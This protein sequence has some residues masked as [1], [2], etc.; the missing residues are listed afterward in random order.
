MGNC[1]AEYSKLLIIDDDQSSICLL[2]VLLRNAGYCK[3]NSVTDPREASRSYAEFEPDL[4]LVDILMPYLDGLEVIEALQGRIP[5]NNYVPIVVLTADA[6]PS[7]RQRALSM[8]VKDFLT[9]PF[10]QTELV[11]RIANLL[12]TR[13]L[14]V[15]IH[16]R[17]QALEEQVRQ[18][19]RALDQAQTDVIECLEKVASLRDGGTSQHC[20][21]VGLLAALIGRAMGFSE[22]RAQLIGAAATLHDIGKVG[23]PDRILLK[24]GKLTREE[25]HQI[26]KHT[27]I[28]AEILAINH[29]SMMKLAEEIA[30][31]HHERWDGGGYNGLKGEDIPASGP[32]CDAGR[33]FR[34]PHARSAV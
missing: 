21:R 25:F 29:F 18:R 8:G 22:D 17:I 34:R 31:Y 7:V 3:L 4:I 32:Y 10:N 23:I 30:F 2:T 9:K 12:E 16:G 33:H 14:H 11:L 13:F 5:R 15:Q 28:G 26:K 20:Q 19:T 24:P 6:D 1:A 27:A